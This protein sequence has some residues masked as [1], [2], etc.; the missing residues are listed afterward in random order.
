MRGHRTTRRRPAAGSTLPTQSTLGGTQSVTLEPTPPTNPTSTTM[1]QTTPTGTTQPQAS[2]STTRKLQTPSNLG[3]RDSFALFSPTSS[4]T[5]NSK[6]K[7]SPFE[8]PAGGMPPKKRAAI[9]PRPEPSLFGSATSPPVTKSP[10]FRGMPKGASVLK[11]F[12]APSTSPQSPPPSSSKRKRP[13]KKPVRDGPPIALYQDPA[14]LQTTTTSQYPG[15]F[16]SNIPAWNPSGIPLQFPTTSTDLDFEYPAI[17]L[18]DAKPRKFYMTL[19]FSPYAVG[20]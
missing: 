10:P 15:R 12:E 6:K 9:S 8:I 4:S 16:V 11:P 13:S 3:Y 17:L 1:P 14:T 7:P 5:S 18:A 19:S 2:A 20:V